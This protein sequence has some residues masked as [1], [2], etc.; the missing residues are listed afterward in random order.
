[1]DR[2][3]IDRLTAATILQRLQIIRGGE[4]TYP[5]YICIEQMNQQNP[6]VLNINDINTD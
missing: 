1:M 2:K 4:I 6:H 5:A 3:H